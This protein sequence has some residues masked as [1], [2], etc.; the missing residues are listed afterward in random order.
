MLHNKAPYFPDFEEIR[1][2]LIPISGG[3]EVDKTDNQDGG[4]DDRQ[5]I[6]HVRT[7]PFGYLQT[8][9]FVG[10]RQELIPAPA[11]AGGAVQD[12]QQGAASAFP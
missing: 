4:D 2:I 9:A 7:H 5:N 1:Y 3:E 10:L 6:G 12:E 8:G 11:V